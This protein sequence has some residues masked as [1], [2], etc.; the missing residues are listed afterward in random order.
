MSDASKTVPAPD[1]VPDEWDFYL[2]RIDD[3]AASFFLNFWYRS[4][5]P[6][7]GMDTLY[8]CD[9][10][11][12]DPGP[13]GLGEADDAA[14]LQEAEE[15]ICSLAAE[16]GLYFVGRIRW[17]GTWLLRLFGPP[18]LTDELKQIAKQVLDKKPSRKFDVD[19]TTDPEWS[20]YY[21]FLC[22]DDERMQWIQDRRV[23]E[24]LMEHG[25]SLTRPRRVDHWIYFEVARKRD[26]FIKA[27]LEDGYQLESAHEDTTSDRK[28]CA[29][30]YRSDKV[31]L[32]EI[33]DV[34]MSLMELAEE[35]DGEY[36]G[37]ETSVEQDN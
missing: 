11:M 19:S 12:L 20:H 26:A 23:V 10:Q 6:L 3:T 16:L 35:H 27:A 37:W 25:D 7:P 13:H 24:N 2:T 4:H 21:D 15:A 28:Y 17:S 5:A 14:R 33:H 18:D 32:E 22:P 9:L 29:Q 8:R 1:A 31:E 30:L 36:D 34:V